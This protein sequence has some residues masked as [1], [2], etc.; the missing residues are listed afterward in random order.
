MPQHCLF[1]RGRDRKACG[2]SGTN[3]GKQVRGHSHSSPPGN[4]MLHLF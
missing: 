2:F 3:P 1:Y 4:K